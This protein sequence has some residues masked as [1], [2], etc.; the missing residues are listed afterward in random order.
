MAKAKRNPQS[1]GAE[2]KTEQEKAENK[3]FVA[4]EEEQED[5][6][7]SFEEL[8]LDARLV[9]ALTKKSVEKPTPIQRV[10]IPLILVC[11]AQFASTYFS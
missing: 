9:R 3:A 4:G 1:D 5:D 2:E 7:Q 11:I 10:A 6:E 8:G